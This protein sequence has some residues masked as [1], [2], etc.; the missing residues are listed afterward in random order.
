MMDDGSK[1]LCEGWE[2]DE[3]GDKDGRDEESIQHPVVGV[4]DIS[5]AAT[6]QSVIMI[7]HLSTMDD[8]LHP[9]G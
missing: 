6:L 4:D 9:A 8:V 1:R 2:G 3:R 5:K 7:G